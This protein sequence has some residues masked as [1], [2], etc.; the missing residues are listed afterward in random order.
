MRSKA[1]KKKTA[2]IGYPEANAVAAM[3]DEELRL[4]MAE[5]GIEPLTRLPA[6]FRSLSADSQPR[7]AGTSFRSI[8]QFMTGLL[9]QPRTIGELTVFALL[10]AC[11]GIIMAQGWRAPVDSI[12]PVALQVVN[13]P[14][15]IQSSKVQIVID[16]SGSLGQVRQSRKNLVTEISAENLPTDTADYTILHLATHGLSNTSVNN[17]FDTLY[18]REF[19]T[20]QL[21]HG[22]FAD[23]NQLTL[24]GSPPYSWYNQVIGADEYRDITFR[25][26]FYKPNNKAIARRR[27]PA[28][29]APEIYLAGSD[30]IYNVLLQRC[31][32][33]SGDC[34]RSQSGSWIVFEDQRLSAR[35]NNCSRGELPRA[36]TAFRFEVSY[37]WRDHH[38]A[39]HRR[40]VQM[41]PTDDEHDL[42]EA[43]VIGRA[44]FPAFREHFLKR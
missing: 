5:Y 7:T 33:S 16:L 30:V 18:Q 32:D 26:L 41:D 13:A 17:D 37:V 39:E 10:V 4:A 42:I 1:G 21:R 25:E 12:S 3:T 28:S 11:F 23:S 44:G 8:C 40:L 31:L 20:N 35:S 15:P 22:P 14:P 36:Q 24:A 29:A 19:G 27:W 6:L 2:F 43:N 34:L 9:R 38:Y